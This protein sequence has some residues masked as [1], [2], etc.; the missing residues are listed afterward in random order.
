MAASFLHSATSRANDVAAAARRIQLEG[1]PLEL[2]RSCLSRSDAKG[3]CSVASAS[4]GLRSTLA[5]G[6]PSVLAELASPVINAELQALLGRIYDAASWLSSRSGI[7]RSSDGKSLFIDVENLRPGRDCWVRRVEFVE[8]EATRRDGVHVLCYMLQRA[9]QGRDISGSRWVLVKWPC[10]CV[11]SES[12]LP[13]IEGELRVTEPTGQQVAMLYDWLHRERAAIEAGCATS[14]LRPSVRT[15]WAEEVTVQVAEEVTTLWHRQECVWTEH[16]YAQQHDPTTWRNAVTV[17][18]L[19]G[20]ADL[21]A[22][23]SSTSADREE[24]ELT[25]YHVA[26]L[27]RDRLPVALHDR[28]GLTVG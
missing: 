20:S 18:G 15:S 6:H 16:Q 22:V 14:A 24:P 28:L 21:L 23:G 2:L 7:R 26:A 8:T 1:L 3:L 11:T 4:R 27:L 25:V 17:G 12:M 9:Y 19:G 5:V 13:S 10:R